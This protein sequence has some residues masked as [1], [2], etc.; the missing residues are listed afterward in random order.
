MNKHR[1]CSRKFIY[2]FANYRIKTKRKRKKTV[3][4]KIHFN[5]AVKC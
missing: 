3:G 5:R 1:K 4:I 2:K